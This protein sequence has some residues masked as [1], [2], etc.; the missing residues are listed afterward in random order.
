MLL[1]EINDV[2]YIWNGKDKNFSSFSNSLNTKYNFLSD[3]WIAF[4]F[5]TIADKCNTQ[6]FYWNLLL[7]NT[8]ED[9]PNV[10]VSEFQN[11]LKNGGFYRNR[12]F[13]KLEIN[14]NIEIYTENFENLEKELFKMKQAFNHSWKI[15]KKV[16]NEEYFLDVILKSFKIT[17]GLKIAGTVVNVIF[18]S[19]AP[20]WV[21]SKVNV[22]N[23]ENLNSPLSTSFVISDSAVSPFYTAICQILETNQTINNFILSFDW[24]NIEINESLNNDS[25]LIFDSKKLNVT[26]NWKEIF[27]LWEFSD[28]PLN[29]PCSL[30]ISY[31]DW[32]IVSYNFY[33]LYSKIIL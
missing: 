22:K 11:V 31:N 12:R 25:I 9:L 4:N 10:W 27:Y 6:N 24:K 19:L 33:F 15:I 29:K 26:L 21:S 17:W 28:I 30:K 8:L 16:W 5:N 14:L 20:F 23:F 13:E 32:I 7:E 3:F 2:N 18:E 1:N